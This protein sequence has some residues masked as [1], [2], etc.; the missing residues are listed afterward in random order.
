MTDLQSFLQIDLPAILAAVLACFSCALVGNYLVLR[1]LSLL[2]DAITP[3]I[4]GLRGA[5]EQKLRFDHDVAIIPIAADSALA[6]YHRHYREWS[7]EMEKIGAWGRDV[8]PS[9]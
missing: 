6:D 4:L 7:T 3:A 2:G 5:S 9:A 8:P 1:R